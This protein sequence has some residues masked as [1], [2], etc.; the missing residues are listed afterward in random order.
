MRFARD[1]HLNRPRV[2]RDSQLILVEPKFAAGEDGGVD[3]HPVA[4]VE[5]YCR[6]VSVS[7]PRGARGL[8]AAHLFLGA[9][10][11]VCRRRFGDHTDSAPRFFG[12]LVKLG[13]LES[14]PSAGAMTAAMRL[15]A[16]YCELI[17]QR[18]ERRW[19]AWFSSAC[20]PDRPEGSRVRAQVSA[21]MLSPPEPLPPPA[22][23]RR[24]SIRAERDR[25]AA[26][27]GSAHETLEA[28]RV[29]LEARL[30]E[31]RAERD[32]AL[33]SQEEARAES[34]RWREEARLK[35][36]E[37]ATALDKMEV[38]RASRHELAARLEGRAQRQE[39]ATDQITK[40]EGRMRELTE[41]AGRAEDE[42]RQLR[43][44]LS[45][46]RQQADAALVQ[47]LRENAE[48][49]VAVKE[50]RAQL[51]SHVMKL[52]KA[53]ERVT[54]LAA[55]LHTATQERDNYR[56]DLLS[57][58]AKLDGMG[59][60]LRRV[61]TIASRS[62][63]RAEDL[64]EQ[65]A[66]IGTIFGLTGG[67]ILVEIERRVEAERRF[68]ERVRRSLEKLCVRCTRALMELE[69]YRSRYLDEEITA[70]L[71]RHL[72]AADETGREIAG[73]SFDALLTGLNTDNRD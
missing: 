60:E 26:A 67:E 68:R 59:H 11:E 38:E 46:L 6:A 54:A 58:R 5:A 31:V 66:R 3:G 65:L 53:D 45:T 32:R 51:D 71:Q 29:N 19:T 61:D 33:L 55:D 39:Q 73:R 25:L 48:L 13:L 16:S 14:C 40:L 36:C 69:I 18:S 4:W 42:A 41:K 15:L 30:A 9:F 56:R 24:G 22:S 52:K 49:K 8:E 7:L 20:D 63:Q 21:A 44:R 64:A 37:L 50:S 62:G 17:T 34:A 28:K 10:P 47:A 12:L 1:S 23:S 43:D 27:L 72:A 57:A 2:A 35:E 70:E